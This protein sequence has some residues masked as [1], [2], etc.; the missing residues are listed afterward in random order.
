[1]NLPPRRTGYRLTTR[2]HNVLA[3]ALVLGLMLAIAIVG[4][5]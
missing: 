2:C 4:R 3:G 1:M 5:S